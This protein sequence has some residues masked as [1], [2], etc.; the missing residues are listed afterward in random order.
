M[1]RTAPNGLDAADWSWADDSLQKL[2]DL[3][4]RPIVG[5]LHHGSGPRST[6]LLD[7]GIGE[8]LAAYASAVA[9]RY[10]WVEDYTPVN[11]PLTT[12]RFSALYGHWYPHAQDDFSFARAL[13]NQCRA[14]VLSMREIRKINSSARLIQT[15]DLGKVFSTPQLAYQAE[16][17]NL[18]RWCTF[19]ILSGHLDR[20]HRMWQYFT[21]LGIHEAELQWFLD[22]A[23]PPDVIGIN[24]YLSGERYLDQNL[25]RYPPYLYGE[26]G[27]ERYADLLASRVL[28][29]GA[30]GPLAL[31]RE[32][33]DRYHIPLAITECH[34]GCTREEQLRWFLEVWRCCG[35]VSRRG[36]GSFSRYGVVSSRGI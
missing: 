17:E 34:N 16:F 35:T 6:N 18:R 28:R 14:I 33:W 36:D 9:R 4:I 27:Q 21:S 32:A 26:N 2:K 25:E 10:P 15:D 22:N 29:D 5:L 23:C 13:L 7:Q 24:H 31:L 20:N 11:E 3:N 8:R 30:A 12:A 19:D 1:E